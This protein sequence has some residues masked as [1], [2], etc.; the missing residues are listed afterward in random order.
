MSRMFF[1]SESVT[2]GHPDKVCDM[3]ADSILDAA[4][5]QDPESHMAV[6][7]TI[8][9]DLILIYGE[10][11][12]KA[13]L[14]YE[15]IALQVM[16]DIG[17]NETYHVLTKVNAQSA[18]INQAVEHDVVSAGDHGIMFGYADDE[19]DTY[20]PFAIQTAHQLAAKLEE[21]RRSD[22]R[23][24]PDGKT[25]VTAE[26]DDGVLRRVDTILISTQH[27]KEITQE[28]LHDLILEKV[29]RP[30]VDSRYIDENTKF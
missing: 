13:Q 10:A 16:K 17:Y 8:K 28:E 22:N 30:V 19:T 11:G 2:S 27:T 7:A 20:M 1:T 15:A 12:T 14:D 3:I 18:E 4:L 26:Y 21:V 25:Q 5:A 29:I 23:L 6:E 24:C 9:D